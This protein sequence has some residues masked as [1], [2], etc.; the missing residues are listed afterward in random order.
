[1]RKK[2]VN[3]RENSVVVVITPLLVGVASAAKLLGVSSAY[4]RGLDRAGKIPGAVAFGGRRKLW[5]TGE[6]RAWIE[7]GCPSRQEWC[8]LRKET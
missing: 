3:V 7:A 1:M 4:F 5:A 2:T 6:L 8:Q